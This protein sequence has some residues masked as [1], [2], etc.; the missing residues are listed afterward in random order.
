MNIDHIR[1]MHETV[2]AQLGG[3]KIFAM[4]FNRAVYGESEVTFHVAPRL[5]TNN[6]ISHVRV[7]LLPSDTYRVE[8]LYIPKRGARK[9]DVITV[10]DVS[11]VFADSLTDL[12]EGRTGLRLSL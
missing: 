1:C 4:A 3:Q 10:D 12:V 5:K 11:G 8:F 2:I 7:S 9:W 6:Q